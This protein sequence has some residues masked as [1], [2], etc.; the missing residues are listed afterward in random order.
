[1]KQ[2]SVVSGCQAG[3][4]HGSDSNGNPLMTNFKAKSQAPVAL[5]LEKT[6]ISNLIPMIVLFLNL[7]AINDLGAH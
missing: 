7:F 4:F 6:G 5:Y 1:M 2:N 3:C